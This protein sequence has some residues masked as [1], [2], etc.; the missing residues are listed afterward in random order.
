MNPKGVK[1]ASEMG[2]SK[3]SNISRCHPSAGR[4]FNNGDCCQDLACNKLNGLSI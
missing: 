3:P 1:Y 4:K 2:Q